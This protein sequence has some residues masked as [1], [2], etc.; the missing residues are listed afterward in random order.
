MDL[1]NA[2]RLIQKINNNDVFN[3]KLFLK[4]IYN[5][6]FIHQASDIKSLDKIMHKKSV[7]GYIG[8]DPTS[9]DLHVGSLVQLMLLYW[10]QYYGHRPIFLMGGGTSLIG[11]PSGKDDI[12]QI[13]SI[14]EINKN[15]KKIELVFSN[16]VNLK[17]KAIIENIPSDIHAE[18]T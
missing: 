7:T 5:R 12:R 4:E 2:Y 15:I 8:F 10:M 1:F 3:E 11:D 18:G 17:K 9:D 14:K 13:I 16:F 6:G